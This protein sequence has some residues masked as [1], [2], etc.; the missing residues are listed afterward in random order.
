MS[1]EQRAEIMQRLTPK[2]YF[3]L[4]TYMFEHPDQIRPEY[5]RPGRE[6]L[7]VFKSQVDEFLPIITKLLEDNELM[8]EALDL[9]I[10]QRENFPE[11]AAENAIKIAHK[12]RVEHN[13]LMNE[14]TSEVK[15]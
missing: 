1:P 8:V 3:N 12:A 9:I 4:E 7:C 5:L 11:E 2:G 10:I 13:D 15:E 6:R 14:L